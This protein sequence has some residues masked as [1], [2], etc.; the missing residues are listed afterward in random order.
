MHSPQLLAHVFFNT[1][2]VL[3]FATAA[4]WLLPVRYLWATGYGPDQIRLAVTWLWL[5][6]PGGTAALWLL[7]WA[8]LRL[9]GRTAV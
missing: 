2:G 6:L 9:V 7:S 1:A 5:I 8:G 3:A 4:S